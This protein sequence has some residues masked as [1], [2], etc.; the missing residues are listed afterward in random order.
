MRQ[1]LAGVLL[2]LAAPA[3][4]AATCEHRSVRLTCEGDGF[5]QRESFRVVLE[6]DADLET[7]SEWSTVLDEHIE[8]TSCEVRVLDPG[9]DEVARVPR[10]KHR[11]VES[12]GF[13]LYDS[14]WLLEV[15]LPPLQIGQRIAVDV[16]TR[17]TPVWP[18][19]TIVLQESRAQRRLE[20]EALCP[21]GR[22]RWHLSPDDGT[23]QVRQEG[24]R[25]LLEA[26]D[27]P[28]RVELEASPDPAL[29]VPSLRL[30][31][32]A[33]PGWP[34]VGAWYDRLRSPVAEAGPAVGAL[35]A[36]LCPEGLPPRARLDAVT[37]YLTRSVRY[38]AV[39][40][41]AGGWV[42]TPPGEVLTRGWGDCKDKSL[43]LHSLLASCGVGSSLVLIRAGDG[44]APD[45]AF[46]SPFWFN[47]CVVGVDAAAAGEG[48]TGADGLVLVDATGSEGGPTW[49]DASCRDRPALVVDGDRSRLVELPPQGQLELTQLEV[50]G[51]LDAAGRFTGAAELRLAGS[52]AAAWNR[53]LR[54]RPGERAE[55]AVTGRFAQLLPGAR[56]TAPSHRAE[57]GERPEV[58]LSATVELEHLATGAPPEPRLHL[59]GLEAAP[60]PRVLDDRTI[61][62]VV[63]PGHFVTRWKLAL[64]EGWC[65]PE[66]R[67]DRVESAIGRGSVEVGRT[68]DGS[69]F[70]E[71][72]LEVDTTQADPGQ[73]EELRALAVFESRANRRSTRLRCGGE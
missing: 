68:S 62:V 35:A 40:I 8:I 41:G 70:V 20:V 14:S 45:P 65:P 33:E 42:P 1:L 16:E 49:V 19:A 59:P 43:L 72:R 69:L 47:H 29:A 51:V 48:G 12:V 15:P 11:R 6:T 24:D 37:E 4:F 27:V 10:R 63:S 26:E 32:P 64:P 38:E 13:G 50:A 54:T 25:L 44:R 5:T 9:G 52:A 71:R 22:L 55:E 57:S 36:R 17:H 28:A 67:S 21:G 31:W 56:L 46:P 39:E 18:G 3:S 53:Y 30:A 58:L 60:D 7:W 2:G 61:P 34:A 23:F 66:E 73:L